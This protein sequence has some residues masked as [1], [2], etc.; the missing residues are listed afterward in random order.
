VTCRPTSMRRS[1]VPPGAH[2]NTGRLRSAG[3]GCLPV[4]RRHSSY[5]ALRLP[6]SH[7]PRLRSSLAFGLPR[8]GRFFCAPLGA[9]STCVRGR[10]ARRRGFTGSPWLRSSSRKS[11]GLPGCWAVLF[12]R[13]VVED[14]ARCGA[15]LAQ[16]GE[17]AAAFRRSN[18]LGT[19][20]V[21][22]FEAAWPTA[23]AFACL[24]INAPVAGNAARLTTGPGGLTPGR[25]GFAPAG[26][27]SGFPELIASFIPPWPAGPGRNSTG[28]PPGLTTLRLADVIERV[29]AV[30]PDEGP[31][32]LVVLG[33]R[34]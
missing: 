34:E 6:R 7:R 15:R 3:S 22:G 5:A 14:P 9:G 28:Y 29:I 30:E 23:H 25:A 10:A 26:R 2:V 8:C 31:C 17:S 18:A 32:P 12:A 13:A 19:R 27:R 1:W 21:I 11:M 20:D 4:P 16:I 24:R 33:Y